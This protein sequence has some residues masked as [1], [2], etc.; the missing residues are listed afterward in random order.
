MGRCSIPVCFTQN[1][2]QSG[3][4]G[5]ESPEQVTKQIV[6]LYK[7]GTGYVSIN[8]LLNRSQNTVAAGSKR[9][10]PLITNGVAVDIYRCSMNASLKTHKM[11][12]FSNMTMI[13]ITARSKMCA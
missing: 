7:D 1:S 10:I 8:M 6:R 11:H 2:Y 5:K 4:H 9:V 13:P 12:E 3:G